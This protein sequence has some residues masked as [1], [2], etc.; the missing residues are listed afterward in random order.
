MTTLARNTLKKEE[1]LSG[2][3]AV[4]ALMARGKWGH[5]GHFK[6]CVLGN[7]LDFCRILVSVPKRNFKR[8]V[9]RNLLKR[10]IREAYRLQKELVSS[11]VAA[12]VPGAVA[13]LPEAVST[14]APGGAVT[15]K[16]FDILFFYN[17]N[18]I[19]DFATIRTEVGEILKQI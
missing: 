11:I 8:A 1:R 13:G 6:Y 12:G 18:E 16:G 3:T 10:R 7:G 15:A 14:N 2:K 17:S 4:S 19:C 5:L 9:K